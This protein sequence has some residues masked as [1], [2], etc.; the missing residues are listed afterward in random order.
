MTSLEKIKKKYLFRKEGEIYQ[1]PEDAYSF[2]RL[3]VF[4]FAD[5][6]VAW[7]L[8]FFPMPQVQR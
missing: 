1:S 5:W 2:G 7:K 6:T 8:I 4:M 3:L